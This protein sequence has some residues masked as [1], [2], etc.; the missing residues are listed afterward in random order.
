VCLSCGC[1]Y[2]ENLDIIITVFFYKF[3]CG[4]VGAPTI[5]SM[6]LPG[7]VT[8]LGVCLHGY[9]ICLAHLRHGLT[10]KYRTITGGSKQKV[11]QAIVVI[12]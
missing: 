4:C 8:E 2:G 5:H 1:V 10:R 7:P 3:L 6:D 11:L 9:T 12:E